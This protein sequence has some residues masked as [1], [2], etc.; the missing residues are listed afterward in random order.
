MSNPA[1]IYK[2]LFGFVWLRLVSF[3]CCH[4]NAIKSNFNFGKVCTYILIS[5]MYNI[6]IFQKFSTIC[7]GRYVIFSKNFLKAF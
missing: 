2:A 1:R 5:N 6:G 4:E 3:S 7:F